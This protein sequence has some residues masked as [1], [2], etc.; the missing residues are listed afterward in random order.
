MAIMGYLC[1]QP[2]REWRKQFGLEAVVE[3]GTWKGE[4]VSTALDA[5][6]PLVV[7]VD[8]KP[9]AE[10]RAL[11]DAPSGDALVMWYTGKTSLQAM[12]R[13]LA[14]VAGKRVLW[15]L[16]AH[17]PE[18]Y[19][20]KAPRTP[21][22]AEVTAI[23]KSPRDHSGDVFVADDMRLYGRECA[24][25][26]MPKEIGRAD[27]DDLGTILEL[28]EPTHRVVFDS[29]DTGYLVASPSGPAGH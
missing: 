10:A 8:V 23:V 16:D 12:N 24:D 13:M 19:N 14:A 29:R 11:M 27:R 21:L 9:T 18:R 28:L 6:F 2:L 4:G 1:R 22:L 15:W 3:T 25:G 20:A 17:L 5:G 26:P 7:T